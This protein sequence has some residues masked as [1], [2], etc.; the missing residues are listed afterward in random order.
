MHEALQLQAEACSRL[1]SV[2][3]AEL[4]G[5]LAD[6][7]ASGGITRS[8]LEGTSDRPVH[9]AVPLRLLGA[10]HRLALTG[11]APGVARHF[12]TTGGAPDD[13]MVADCLA[14]LGR[15]RTYVSGALSGQVQTNEVGR[16]IVPLV[17]ARWLATIGVQSYAHLEFGAS[18]GLNL[19]F[20]RYGADDGAVSMGDAESS[21][22]FGPQWFAGPPPLPAAA[23]TPSVVRGADPH[24]VDIGTADGRA[25]LLSFIWPDQTERFARA[26]A[27]L[28]IAV[29]HPTRVD[30]ASADT[31]LAA[32]LP[33][34]RTT[35]TMV[36]HSIVW[37]YLGPAVQK[38]VQDTL[39]DEGSQRAEDAPLVWARMEPAGAVADVRATVWREG[40][41]ED[42]A[43]AEVGFHGHGLRWCD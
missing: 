43:L 1:G 11:A 38:S 3:Y 28:A 29:A 13:S 14:A 37:Q 12:P 31:W 33:Q 5:A 19:N 23:A 41:R 16:S 26:Q 6:D 27:A 32:E 17:L 4:L 42:F 2:L 24:P 10:I 9:D 18:A 8:L 21:V 15:H 22:R 39:A 34:L 20:V 36:F 7:Y 40:R 35:P 25:R 30:R